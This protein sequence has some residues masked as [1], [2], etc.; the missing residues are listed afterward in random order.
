[1]LPFPFRRSLV[2]VA[3]CA[4]GTMSA[5]S[6]DPELLRRAVALNADLRSYQAAV[7]VNVALTSF[8]FLSTAL[9]GNVY[10]ERP[11]RQA[12]VFQSVPA[13]AGEFRKVYPK[14]DPPA[15]WPA[16]YRISALGDTGT[17][18]TFRLVPLH[19]GRVAHLDV[20]ID[21]R[22]ATIAG[23]VWTYTDGGSVAF[24]QRFAVYDGR[25][26]VAAQTG[27]VDLPAYK[28]EV[29]STF[30]NYRLNAPIPSDVFGPP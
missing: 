8:P 5:A 1:M 15:S 30:S 21:D 27:H 14:L 13:L 10:Y 3:L 29:T 16:L 11:D 18:T 23:Y 20:A 28:A 7:H 2:F 22:A 4:F 26:L 19:I 12:I 25:T 24:T 9:D 6:A 17:V